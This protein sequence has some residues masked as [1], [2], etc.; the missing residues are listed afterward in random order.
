MVVVVELDRRNGASPEMKLGVERAAGDDPVAVLRTEDR[1][2]CMA[3][4]ILLG[5]I[6]CGCREIQANAARR[7]HGRTLKA[8]RPGRT[9]TVRKT[10]WLEV[11]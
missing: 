4:R 1:R 10:G 3:R 11:M 2:G 7:Y 5:D 8:I 6:F 9:T